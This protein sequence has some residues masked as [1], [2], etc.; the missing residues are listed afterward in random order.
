MHTH[1]LFNKYKSLPL[2]NCEKMFQSPS[3]GGG[4]QIPL[5]G[6]KD[7]SLILSPSL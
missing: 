6:L 3:E 2:F 5:Q 7:C 1:I 4:L